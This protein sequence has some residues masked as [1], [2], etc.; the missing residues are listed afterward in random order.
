MLRADKIFEEK[1][2]TWAFWWGERNRPKA[3]MPMQE[4]EHIDT[5]YTETS[6]D[7]MHYL[8]NRG[9]RSNTP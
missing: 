7:L 2:N 3:W 1:L 4:Q 9:Y 8:E 5:R 6:D